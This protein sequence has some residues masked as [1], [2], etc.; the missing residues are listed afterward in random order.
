M[1]DLQKFVLEKTLER[2][3]F[4]I[5]VPFLRDKYRLPTLT[6]CRNQLHELSRRQLVYFHRLDGAVHAYPAVPNH[7]N[8]VSRCRTVGFPEDKQ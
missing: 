3:D 5:N 8:R 6:E 1:T 2:R 4:I 7:P